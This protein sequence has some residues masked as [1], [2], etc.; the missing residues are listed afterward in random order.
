[1]E[2]NN[3]AWPHIRRITHMMMMTD[4]ACFDFHMFNSK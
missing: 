1:M 4:R 3:K 2:N